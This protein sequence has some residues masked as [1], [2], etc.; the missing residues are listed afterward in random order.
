MNLS[1]LLRSQVIDGDGTRL[2]T[3]E[4]VRVTQDG[5]L[6]LP[7]GAAFRV[8]GLIVGRRG[9]AARLGYNRAKIKGPWLLRIILATLARHARYIPWNAVTEWDGQTVHVAINSQDA[10]DEA[11]G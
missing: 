10:P 8:E 1:D 6:L 4:D 9:I 7:F 5:P 3:V 2:G 11:L